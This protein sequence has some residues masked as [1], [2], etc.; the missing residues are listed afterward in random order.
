MKHPDPAIFAAM[1]RTTRVIEA[2]TPWS[3]RSNACS[4]SDSR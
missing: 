2:F 3:L 1:T 4:P